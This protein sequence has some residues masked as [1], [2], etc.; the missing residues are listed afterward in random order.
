MR[1]NRIKTQ[2]DEC[3]KVLYRIPS[4]LKNFKYQFCNREC[5]GKWQSR[6][7]NGENSS[8]FNG[9]LVTK[10]CLHCGESH[11]VTRSLG[12]RSKYCSYRCYWDAMHL[13]NTT[14]TQCHNCKKE[15]RIVNSKLKK[16]NHYFCGVA[17]QRRFMR[18]DRIYNWISDRSKLK[19]FNSSLRECA[20]SKK[21]RKKI[22]KRDNYTCKACGLKQSRRE[23][24]N[25]NVHH[26]KKISDYPGLI[27][28]L[29]NGI[30]LCEK[31]HRK[32]LGKE[33]KYEIKYLKL[34]YNF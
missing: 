21:W 10:H 9:G 6:T 33:E 7:R 16:H 13:K 18:K 25:L 30:T 14:T 3:S 5:Q 32:T 11:N 15:I 28:K 34:V 17:C 19:D 26:I 2:C 23:N 8:R 20:D 29:W 4:R 1:K 31:C 12:Q 24:I 22:F 27:L